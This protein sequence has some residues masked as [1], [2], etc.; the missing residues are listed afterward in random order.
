MTSST[1]SYILGGGL[2]QLWNIVGIILYYDIALSDIIK[3]YIKIM[4]R[5]N[6]FGTCSTCFYIQSGCIYISEVQ[7]IIGS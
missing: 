2:S 1:S 7:N 6:G 5:L 3:L 4:S